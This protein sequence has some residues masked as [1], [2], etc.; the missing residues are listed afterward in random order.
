M[1][2][3]TYG[4]RSSAYHSTRSLT[5]TALDVDDEITAQV[6]RNVFYVDDALTGADIVEE[7]VVL[8]DNLVSTLKKG[9]FDLRKWSS[10]CPQ[11]I[12]RLPILLQEAPKAYTICDKQYSI[13]TLGV[14][15][16]PI[17]DQFSFTVTRMPEI[18]KLT[19]R[20]LL[21]DV[22]TFYDPM[23]WLS[24]TILQF[25]I[26]LKE[27][28]L[29]G[30]DWDERLPESIEMSWRN[31]RGE[32]SLFQNLTIN[33][34][35]THQSPI[36]EMQLHVFCDASE[37]AFAA[38]V[39]SRCTDA[40]GNVVV[41]LLSAKTKLSPIKQISIPRLELSAAALGCKLLKACL[42]AFSSQKK[43]MLKPIGW[44]DSTVVLSWINDHPAKWSCFVGNRTTA[45][46]E[47]I[48]PAPWKHVP[49]AENPAD[50]AFRGLAPS[51]LL[52]HKLWW[53]GPSWLAE[54]PITW[55]QQPSI[56]SNEDSERRKRTIHHAYK[57]PLCQPFET[58]FSVMSR[59]VRVTAWLLRA[60]KLLRKIT[61]PQDNLMA[62]ELVTAL[63]AVLASHQK[64]FFNDE[65]SQL[66][67]ETSYRGALLSLTP[68]VENDSG[69]LRVGGRLAQSDH[70]NDLKFPILIDGKSHLATLLI[71]QAHTETMHGS[72]QATLSHLRQRYWITGGKKVI[73]K[74]TQSCITCRRF[75]RRLAS[76]NPIM[77]D[78]PQ[79]RITQSRPFTHVGIDFGGPI[80]LKTSSK[81]VGKAYIALLVCFTTKAVHIELV[82][83]LSTPSCVSALIRFIARRGKPACIYSDNATNFIGARNEMIALREILGNDKKNPA[84]SF[85]IQQGVDWVTIPLRAPHFGGLWEAGIKSCKNHLRKVVGT[86]ALTF[87]KSTLSSPKSKVL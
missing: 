20:K 35:L 75:A 52:S 23:G 10:N 42:D 44:T 16:H 87:E 2:R 64:D 24:P 7:A 9:G 8:Q 13:K 46:Q 71:R 30:S 40:N 34:P 11:V 80:S 79:E 15:W 70:S 6:I 38:A 43:P 45:I 37:R 1:T 14:K 39:Y 76:A 48:P 82:S 36:V 73:T 85:I 86:Q 59:L 19:K 55:P 68:F 28:W 54:N 69:L 77:G 49:S 47:I 62:D 5:E 33:R 81:S 18:S 29:A 26:L 65:I 3:V 57:V 50:C 63:H 66:S 60:S 74:V 21:S 4:I 72:P 27:C 83:S 53:N 41:S 78:L 58:R 56:I 67:E 51:L 17:T 61:T 31:S 22:S 25:K 12:T 32:L 84:A